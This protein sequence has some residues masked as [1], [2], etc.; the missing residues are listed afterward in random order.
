MGSIGRR[1]FGVAVL[2]GL[3]VWAPGPADGG[4]TADGDRQISGEYVAT[5][6]S[7]REHDGLDGPEV[8]PSGPFATLP[9]VSEELQRAIAGA[10]S[11]EL[12]RVIVQ[13]RHLPQNRMAA[14]VNEAHAAERDAIRDEVGKILAAAAERRDPTLPADAMNYGELVRTLPQDRAALRNVHE[15]SE[16]HALLVANELSARLSVELAPHLARVRSEIERLGGEFESAIVAGSLVVARV[17]AAR[18]AE[19]GRHSDVL[20]ISEDRLESAQL[21]NMDDATRVSAS[22]GLWDAGETGGL[23]DP[24][25]IDSGLD[26]LHPA[27]TDGTSPQRTNFY[28][29][30]LSSGATSPFFDDF[31]NQDDYYGHGTHVSGIVGS[32]GSTGY[33]SHLGMSYGVA[34]LVTLKAGWRNTG[35]TAS[36]NTSDRQN[37]IERALNNTSALFPSGTFNDDVDGI[38]I[39][40]SSEESS[41]DTDDSRFLDSV[42]STY[43]DLPVTVSAGNSGPNNT[44]FRS[45][46][47]AYN[48]ITVANVWDQGTPD[49]SDD[50]TWSTSTVGPTANGRR[51]PDLA[52]PGT[53]IQ[54]PAHNWEGG[55]PDFVSGTGTSMAAPAV[56]GVIMDLMDAGV[57]DELE[58]KALLINTAQKNEPG[59]DIE[60]DADGWDEQVGW[61]YMNAWA[62]YYHRNDVITSSVTPRN[63]TGEY[64][65]FRGTMRDEQM[66]EG[67]DRVTMVWNRHATYNPAAP[68]TEYF[69][70]V[71]LNLRLYRELDDYLYDLDTTVLD[72]VHQVR[73]NGGA[74][75]TD[76][77][78]RAYAWSTS[79]SHGGAT[80]SF[81]LA[82]EEGFT[83]VSLPD[84]DDF[85]GLV[86]W[87]P[88][89]EPGEEFD[90]EI[91]IRNDGEIASHNNTF[92]LDLPS[93][94][95][96][97]SGPEVQN[98]G[99]AAG[100]GGE[101]A[102]AAWTI[103]A[104]PT[105]PTGPSGALI[106]FT[107]DSYGIA[108]GTVNWNPNIFVQWDTTPPTPNP[109][110]FS[111]PPTA[112]DEFSL[113]MEVATASDQHEPVEYFMVF[114]SSP[115]GGSGGSSRSWLED[116]HHTD[117]GLQANNEY[118]Y[119]PV[120]RDSAA[121]QNQTS[122]PPS[123]WGCI[124]THIETAPAPNLAPSSTTE[125]TVAPV[126]PITNLASDSS[127]L[128]IDNLTVGSNSGWR[129]SMSGWGDTGLSANTEYTWAIRTR[130]G[131]GIESPVGPGASKY[132]LIEGPSAPTVTVVSTTAV[133]T[134]SQGSYSNLTL[135]FSGLRVDNLTQGTDSGWVQGQVSWTSTGLT[136][137]T[138]YL[139][140]GLS[141][142]GDGFA[143]PSGPVVSARTLA[144]AP[145]P[146]AA[147]PR[148][149]ASITARWSANGNPAGTE[150]FVE[151]TTSGA[152]SGW[153]TALEWADASTGPGAVYS[154]QGRARNG[155]GLETAIIS[156]GDVESPFWGD[157]FESGNSSAWSSVT[158]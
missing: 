71:D 124:Y 128:R 16:A 106:P 58:L 17:P 147:W 39:S 12:L 148:T 4:P 87:F 57:T 50:V 59:I 99:S 104:S 115:T 13:L 27:M 41:D 136:P 133:D 55:N 45:P 51:K 26:L 52:A 151:N 84:Q 76:V 132:T 32:Y 62:A 30:F 61:G 6:F 96:I 131:N 91:W 83:E 1:F 79:F 46:S 29:W 68:P 121:A 118:C 92:D 158:P 5:D 90:L 42:I 47:L 146:A 33:T 56:L 157:G 108:W 126:G 88:T 150:Y 34:K 138:E 145:A 70:L 130:N 135:G 153:T 86:S 7:G 154:Y 98:V 11:D 127:G 38:N 100:G 15:R 107:H 53:Y 93:G 122:T 77:I 116:R 10:P 97:V 19:L 49:R 139:F 48:V 64:R 9:V 140:A 43:Q 95:S 125:M 8:D 66:G 89:V 120:A 111:S 3:V 137:N 60:D 78:V 110:P 109:L 72:N 75:S 20:R 103:Q 149:H 142:N 105:A 141:R 80:E 54:A 112:I 24:A 63:T 21:D 94:W 117:D 37:I 40:Y 25:I 67:R 23:F 18:I 36:M 155:D 123:S 119:A 74:G 101:S 114:V 152:S 85:A 82:T 144:A 35:G 129:Q 65:L 28:T 31:A 73:I 143:N 102:H 134:Q 14:E 44:H 156:F 22:G 69:N 2:V 113:E 81:A